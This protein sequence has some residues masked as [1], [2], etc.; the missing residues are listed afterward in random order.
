MKILLFTPF[1]NRWRQST[2]E[3]FEKKG[4]NAEWFP[5]RQEV[6]IND[7]NRSDILF[8]M[9]CD[10]TLI[11]LTHKFDKPIYTYIRS[12]EVYFD[13][14][15]KVDWSKIKGIFF[16][17]KHVQR[18]ANHKFQSLI[19]GIPQYYIPN[20]IDVSE[21]PFKQN[22]NNHRI[23]MVCHLNSKKNIPLALQVAM[24]LPDSYSLYLAGGLQDEMIGYYIDYF[25]H[26][27]NGK[28][29]YIGKVPFE[30]MKDFM[31]DKDYIISTSLKEGCPM[32][33]LEGMASGLKPVI[34]NW[35]G[36]LDL[37][38]QR[39]VFNTIDEAKQIIQSEDYNPEEYR[40][41]GIDNH[42]P[43]LADK[44]VEVVRNYCISNNKKIDFNCLKEF[45]IYICW[46]TSIISLN[47]ILT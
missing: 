43:K 28:F 41:F 39:W 8:S 12:Y 11:G 35:P 46:I 38:P 23:A 29:R 16:C 15:K 33:V 14:A 2:K 18:L 9:W 30:K 36:A 25:G 42:N 20:W 21:W 45:V 3:A 47:E 1:E 26:L 27:L 4:H 19:K 22:I 32:N 34:H 44:I 17:S 13:Y 37:F 5:V 7:M 31:S 40:Q 10:E 24:M 6:N